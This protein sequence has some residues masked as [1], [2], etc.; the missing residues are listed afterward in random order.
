MNTFWEPKLNHD[1]FG[2]TSGVFSYLLWGFLPLYWKLLA[3]I[4]SKEIICHRCFWS[5][6]LVVV[7]FLIR[8]PSK[9]IEDFLSIK[10]TYW[11]A[12]V[13]GTFCISLNWFINVKAVNTGHIVES[14]LGY[15][16]NPI[17]SVFLGT[18]FFK[19]RLNSNQ[20]IAV[21][22]ASV[23]VLLLIYLGGEVP[24]ISLSIT[25]T[26]GGY[27][28]FK[29]LSPVSTTLRMLI[30][31]SILSAFLIPILYYWEYTNEF[32]FQSYS[33]STK[34]LLFGAGFA[35]ILPLLCFGHAVIN[36]NLSTLGFLQYIAPTLQFLM[37]ILVFN[38]K[39][40]ASYFVAFGFIWLA[41]ALYTADCV[42]S[43]K[44][45][46]TTSIVVIDVR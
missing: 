44:K 18:V 32:N 20:W 41:I 15:Y 39:L 1:K 25:L 6:I 11:F 29:K 16:I 34:I 43:M 3:D 46:V 13:A 35:T 12:I 45:K 24:W 7:I 37:G 4:D 36:L 10:K 40:S 22:I 33:F 38:E 9:K 23:G 31:L 14:S 28:L 17:F 8:N 27:G 30:E 26:F 21:I 5:L 42:L 19:E 2:L